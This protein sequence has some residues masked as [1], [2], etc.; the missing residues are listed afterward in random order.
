MERKDLGGVTPAMSAS[1]ADMPDAP[2]CGTS[3]DDLLAQVKAGVISNEELHAQTGYYNQA[4]EVSVYK[5]RRKSDGVWSRGGLSPF[6]ADSNRFSAGKA[7]S[8]ERDVRAHLRQ[9]K[10]YAPL[11]GPGSIADL[12]VVE[13]RQSGLFAGRTVPALEFL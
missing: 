5:I 8:R 10:D 6:K 13:F 12:E 3:V 1:S 9:Y 11:L 4:P 2:N 7:W